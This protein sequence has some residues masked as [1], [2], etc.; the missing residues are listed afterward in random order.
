MYSM[1][2]LIFFSFLSLLGCLYWRVKSLS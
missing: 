2:L 1:L